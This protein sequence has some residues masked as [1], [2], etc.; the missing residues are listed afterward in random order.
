MKKAA[1]LYESRLGTTKRFAENISEYLKSKKISA[2]VSAI[3]FYNDSEIHDSDVVFL[4]CWT[5]GLMLMFQHPTKKWKQSLNETNGFSDKKVVLFT[6][7]NI[8]TGSMFR[9]ME[10]ALQHKNVAVI[11]RIKSR[12]GL[13]DDQLK[14]EL[15]ALISS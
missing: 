12:K 4:G 14:Q 7:Y 5:N 10:Q 9:K 3:D 6:T 8:L 1:I 2:S 15:D 13:L 11:G